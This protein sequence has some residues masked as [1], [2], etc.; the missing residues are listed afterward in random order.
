MQVKPVGCQNGRVRELVRMPGC[1][2]VRNG[3]PASAGPSIARKADLRRASPPFATPPTAPYHDFH[4]PPPDRASALRRAPA[5]AQR[6]HQSDGR[7]EPA[8]RAPERRLLVV[9]PRRLHRD[10]CGLGISPLVLIQRETLRQRLIRIS[11]V[12]AKRTWRAGRRSSDFDPLAV[13]SLGPE[14]IPKNY[15]SYCA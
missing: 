14:N 13:N 1:G 15:R 4:S 11:E 8:L 7:D 5:A 2:R 10:H 3:S 12:G 6:L 9:E